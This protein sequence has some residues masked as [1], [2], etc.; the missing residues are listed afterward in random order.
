MSTP[1]KKQQQPPPYR[2]IKR[3]LDGESPSFSPSAKRY[4]STGDDFEVRA[5]QY[6]DKMQTN[7]EIHQS[8]SVCPVMKVIIDTEVFQRLRYIK[9]LGTSEFLYD[10]ANHTRFMHSLGVAHLAERMAET[11]KQ[12]QPNLGA[13]EKD[14]LCVKLAGLLHDI[15]HGPY[16]H[17]YESFREDALPKFLKEHPDLADC[18]ADCQDLKVPMA[19]S[20]ELSSLQLIDIALEELGLKID[21]DN[22][23]KPLKQIGHGIDANSIRV[24]KPPGVKDSVLTSRDFVFV[25][26]CILGRPLPEVIDKL[27]SNSFIGR[28]KPTQEWLYDIVNNRHSGLDVDKID[29]FARD[30]IRTMG[31]GR[32]DSKLIEDARVAK[33]L[34]TRPEKCHRCNGTPGFHFM[35]CY[36]RKHVEASMNF[37][38][39]RLRLHTLIYQHKKTV[40]VESKISKR[41][42]HELL[43]LLSKL[44]FWFSFEISPSCLLYHLWKY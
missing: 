42:E 23:D 9:Q 26:E 39:E 19:W 38:K 18:Y 35:I 41:R 30:H 40:A 10:C 32:I 11:I 2:L 21:L 4:K 24:F 29:Y 5:L 43:E 44:L 16:S 25:K 15:G 7:D 31:T 28:T 1:S 27:D 37:F 33:A 12:E 17:L 6:D 36:P 8:I 22:L 20:H 14:V 34:C 3:P 13:T